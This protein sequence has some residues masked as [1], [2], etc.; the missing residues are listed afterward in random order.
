MLAKFKQAMLMDTTETMGH[1]SAV[2]TEIHLL[3][4]H[5]RLHIVP[6]HQVIPILIP[7]T[8]L[9]L[10]TK[11]VIISQVPAHTF[12]VTTK[13]I[14]T[15]ARGIIGK[16]YMDIKLVAILILS[17]YFAFFWP[18][19]SGSLLGLLSPISLI[20]FLITVVRLILLFLSNIRK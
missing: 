1:M 11:M 16:T 8:K 6:T 17:G 18:V 7:H 15:I 10:S 5:I 9:V 14:Q 12:R 19:P 3:T 4:T 2:T 13:L 20:V